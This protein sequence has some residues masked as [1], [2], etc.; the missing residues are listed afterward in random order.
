M[1][2]LGCKSGALASTGTEL[3]LIYHIKGPQTLLTLSYLGP[4]PFPS[5]GGLNQIPS[6]AACQSPSA[7]L[8]TLMGT[9]WR[10]AQCHQP[11][12]EL[13]TILTPTCWLSLIS[14]PMQPPGSAESTTGATPPQPFRMGTWGTLIALYRNRALAKEEGRARERFQVIMIPVI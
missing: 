10:A 13:M 11:H 8:G 4:F 3:A 5:V 2:P 6:S 7:S 1:Q 9:A 12:G 14:E